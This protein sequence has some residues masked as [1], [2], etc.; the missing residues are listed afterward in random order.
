MTLQ[1][2]AIG[3]AWASII[4]FFALIIY[5]FYKATTMPLN[6]RW[7]VYPVP[8]E[9][10]E[11]REY[12]GSYMEQVDWVEKTKSTSKSAELREMGAEIFFLKRVRE[13][14][15]YQLWPLSMTMHWGLYLLV[16]W[17]V[18]L[19]VGNW[20][21]FLE[22]I[23]IL[24]GVVSLMLGIIGSLG[25]IIKRA[26]NQNLRLYTAPIDYFNLLFLTVFFGLGII[27]W[28]ADPGFTGHQT[29]LSNMLSFRPIP[30]HPIV[31]GM[32]FT[33]QAFVIYM[34]FSKLIHYVMKHFTFT[35]TLW[36]D[37]FNLKGSDKDQQIE[38]Q[39]AYT[40]G[41]AAPHFSADKNWLEDAQ[42]AS[43]GEKTE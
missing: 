21:P 32:F 13:H 4:I 5:K 18:L 14:N 31:I 23:T 41:W 12:G 10:D 43:V 3:F 29:Y 42:T 28:L 34:P 11:K 16:V 33:L 2:F 35:E 37:T 30:V 25:L 40:K 24:I 6:L 27:S 1:W 38:R 36:D 7:E 22:S 19:M 26:T 8:H 39:L 20:L 9:T 15:P 17:I